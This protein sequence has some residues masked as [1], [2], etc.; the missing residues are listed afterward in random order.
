MHL[1]RAYSDLD[2]KEGDLSVAEEISK[3]VLSIP[4]YYGMMDNQISYIVKCINTFC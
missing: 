3:T 4:M 2:M 1:Q